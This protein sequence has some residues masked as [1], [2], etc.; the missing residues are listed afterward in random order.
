MEIKPQNT[1]KRYVNVEIPTRDGIILRADLYMPAGEGPFPCIVMRSPYLKSM[2]VTPH[3]SQWGKY[4]AERGFSFLMCDVRGREIRMAYFIL[5]LMRSM[6][7][8]TPL[9]GP[10]LNPGAPAW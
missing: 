10:L 1:I 4:Y 7:A 2:A 5:S 3:Y 8:T 9:S 6:T